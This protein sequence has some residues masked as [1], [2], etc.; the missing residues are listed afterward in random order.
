MAMSKFGS[1]QNMN[2]NILIK[3]KVEDLML[4]AGEILSEV[5]YEKFTSGIISQ[6]ELARYFDLIHSWSREGEELLKILK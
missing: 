5:G 2:D 3:E 1:H 6:G 4:Y